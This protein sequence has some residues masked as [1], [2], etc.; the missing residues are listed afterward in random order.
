MK[1]KELIKY[2]EPTQKIIV[3]LSWHKEIFKGM[4]KQL[5]PFDEYINNLDVM[6]IYT[7]LDLYARGFIKIQVKKEN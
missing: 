1:I 5:N 6:F 4:A 3:C 2:F 7:D